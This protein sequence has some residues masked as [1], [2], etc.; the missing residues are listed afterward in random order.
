MDWKNAGRRREETSRS[1]YEEDLSD[2]PLMNKEPSSLDDSRRFAKRIIAIG[3]SEICRRRLAIPDEEFLVRCASYRG[4]IVKVLHPFIEG[5]DRRTNRV[6]R[7]LRTILDLTEK[8][9]LESVSLVICKEKCRRCALN[10]W[11][12]THCAK[13]TTENPTEVYNFQVEKSL[14]GE[15]NEQGIIDDVRVELTKISDK[16]VF[17]N[18]TQELIEGIKNKNFTCY[19][20]GTKLYY[21]IRLT[22]NKNAPAVYNDDLG[23]LCDHGWLNGSKLRR[24]KN[25]CTPL[26]YKVKTRMESSDDEFYGYDDDDDMEIGPD[27]QDAIDQMSD[28]D[29]EVAVPAPAP[30]NPVGRRER[31]DSDNNYFAEYDDNGYRVPRRELR[32]GTLTSAP[33]QNYRSSHSPSREANK[34][35]LDRSVK[36]HAAKTIDQIDQGMKL[37][38]ITYKN[39]ISYKLDLDNIGIAQIP[40]MIYNYQVQLDFDLLDD[41]EEKLL[42]DPSGIKAD[43]VANGLMTCSE[44]DKL[45]NFLFAKHEN[46]EIIAVNQSKYKKFKKGI[47]K[48]AV[49]ELKETEWKL[50]EEKIKECVDAVKVIS[51]EVLRAKHISNIYKNRSNFPIDKLDEELDR[52]EDIFEADVDAE[53]AETMARF[54]NSMKQYR[55]LFRNYLGDQDSEDD[56]LVMEEEDLVS[57]CPISKTPIRMAARTTCKHIFDYNSLI[58]IYEQKFGK[59]IKDRPEVCP[60]PGCQAEFTKL[61]IR[62][63]EIYQRKLDLARENGEID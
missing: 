20:P 39:S 54:T 26:S 42:S 50:P 43:M 58:N 49:K 38:T 31:R 35:N 57:K 33:N 53:G 22:L 11:R 15:V 12:D 59:R 45:E 19:P 27:A 7:W 52:R 23:D 40:E 46:N 3:I 5:K 41:F 14:S 48:K 24:V 62:K 29:E 21:A 55:H 56:D 61:D 8:D 44:D 10:R 30:V 13:C 16:M 2:G 51:G 9:W 60:Q 4:T 34:E 37:A 25:P 63:D 36:E 18:S 28:S 32:G 47:T 17:Q 1:L 6:R